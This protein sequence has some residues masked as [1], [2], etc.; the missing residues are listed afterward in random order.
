M[1]S[2]LELK[3]IDASKYRSSPSILTIAHRLEEIYSMMLD[4]VLHHANQR[5]QAQ[6]RHTLGPLR[7][8]LSRT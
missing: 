8:K 1:Y 3:I 4:L 7:S 6:V 2:R 5:Y